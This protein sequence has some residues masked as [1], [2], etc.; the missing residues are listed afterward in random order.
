MG[1]T[2][3]SCLTLGVGKSVNRFRSPARRQRQL[4]ASSR[5]DY[6][7]ALSVALLAFALYL[8]TLA[9]GLLWGDSGEFQFAA[10]LGGF[11]HPTGYPLY[12]ILGYLWTHLLPLHDPAWRMNAFSALWGGVAAGL[13]YFLALRLF[14]CD[15]PSNDPA[16]R[17]GH[18]WADRLPSRLAALLAALTFAVTPTFWSQAV[19]AEVYTLHAAFVA[20]IFLS[21][22]AW[23]ESRDPRAGY[24]AAGLIGLS[25]A[26]HRTTVLLI[27]AIALYVW[28]SR[29]HPKEGSAASCGRPS[30]GEGES[31][32]YVPV[33]ARARRNL[34][35]VALVLLP[36]A[37][38]AW[39]PLA[40]QRAPYRTLALGPA[41]TLALYAPTLNGFLA[42]I[43][44]QVF[45]GAIG[46]PAQAMARVIPAA[47]LLVNEVSWAG[48]VLGV[49]G[50]AWS[51]WRNPRA[52]AL[53]GLSFLTTVGFN[54]FYGIGDIYAFYIPAYLVWTLW[55]AAGA[56][57]IASSLVRWWAGRGRI[58]RVS[59]FAWLLGFLLPAWLLVTHFA[60]LDQSR[61][62]TARASWE[63]ILSQPLPPD[64]I[65]VSNDRDEMMPLWYMK[66]VEGRR[67]DLIGLFPLIQA[68]PD[69]SDVAQT[70]GQALRSGRPV[71]LV[72]PMPGL[73]VKLTLGAAMGE[74]VGLLGPLVPVVGPAVT[75]TPDR[76]VDVTF[77]D[78][79]RLIGYDLRPQSLGPDGELVVVLY[80]QPLRSLD[81]DYTTFVHVIAADGAKI[82]QS[83]QRPGGIYY[84]TSLWR[85][86]DIL[87]D[88]HRIRLGNSLGPPPYALDVGLYTG[89]VELRH[90]GQPQRIGPLELSSL[91]DIG[92]VVYS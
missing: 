54:L 25:L 79:V 47:R 19:I 69:W 58:A 23:G 92:L 90:L 78:A 17:L 16:G 68:G 15:R 6:V 32:A 7:V 91:R 9:P 33:R 10:W 73:E 2:G 83:D 18:R 80:W 60:A 86:G 30:A 82:G 27:P 87:A 43:T 14:R 44:G 53:T 67:P 34:L 21:V 45:A 4:P 64:A 28:L 3:L 52:L 85:I 65:L 48:L 75:R 40:G 41:Q 26:H 22:V 5:G 72:K 84:P 1:R 66:Y 39:T 46:T 70:V 55:M 89:A 88:E 38:Y 29:R 56:A 37:L 42:H 20:A 13:V 11:V 8:R 63:S 36:L 71:Y 61:N 12:L 76:L 62:A 59:R 49:L 35:T 31:T 51:A 74:Q 77:G 24:A 81:A 57:A 50:L